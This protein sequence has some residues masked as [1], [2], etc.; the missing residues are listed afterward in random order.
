MRLLLLV[1][2]ALVAAPLAAQTTHTVMVRNFEFEPAALTIEVGDTVRWENEVGF[3]NARQTSG[4]ETF[5]SGSPASDMW[6]YEFTFTQVG[7][8]AYQCDPHLNIMQGTITVVQS[9]D[10]EGPLVEEPEGLQYAGANPFRDT[11]RLTLALRE[12]QEVRVSVYDA[13]GREVAVLF[14]GEAP[15]GDLPV[16]WTAPESAQGAFIVRAAGPTLESTLGIVRVYSGPMPSG[17]H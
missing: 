10:A 7:T 15:A 6:T 3:H 16:E 4:P 2:A 1:L 9:T 14:E 5:S 12:P 11:A 13:L 8:N 17:H